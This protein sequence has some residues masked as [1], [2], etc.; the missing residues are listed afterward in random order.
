MKADSI[1][2]R[3][4]PV[5]GRIAGLAIGWRE[6]LTIGIV[7]NGIDVTKARKPELVREGICREGQ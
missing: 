1:G 2:R 7:S 3:A 6:V 5:R 4:A